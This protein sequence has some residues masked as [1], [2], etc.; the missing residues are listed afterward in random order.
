[1]LND[2]DQTQLGT[3]QEG[4]TRLTSI[5]LGSTVIRAIT[6]YYPSHRNPSP[7][8]EDGNLRSR[9]LRPSFTIIIRSQPVSGGALVSQQPDLARPG[10]TRRESLNIGPG[11]SRVPSRTEVKDPDARPTIGEVPGPRRDAPKSFLP[12]PPVTT[13]PPVPPATA[14][15]SVP[16]VPIAPVPPP[17]AR[18]IAASVQDFPAFDFTVLQSA[19]NA[20][21]VPGPGSERFEHE[22]MNIS[23]RTSPAPETTQPAASL[24]HSRLRSLPWSPRHNLA[25][26]VAGRLQTSPLTVHSET[27]TV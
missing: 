27:E 16:S 25:K 23:P 8:N 14:V 15:P 22:D 4:E 24:L 21:N 11:R 7:E 18:P 13:V 2:I 17:V 10:T 20:L 9:L 6:T 12:P 5:N 19:N 26:D 1:M 3:P